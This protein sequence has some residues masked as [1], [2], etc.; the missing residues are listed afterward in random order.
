LMPAGIFVGAAGSLEAGHL[1][2]SGTCCDIAV[3]GDAGCDG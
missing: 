3:S 1:T 2:G